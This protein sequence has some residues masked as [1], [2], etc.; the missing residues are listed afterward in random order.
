[1]QGYKYELSPKIIL[2]SMGNKFLTNVNMRDKFHFSDIHGRMKTMDPVLSQCNALWVSLTLL[3]THCVHTLN[4]SSSELRLRR[5]H[6]DFDF[7]SRS[8]LVP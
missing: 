8:H 7:D 3:V 4:S 5:Y 2:K 1:M 6:V